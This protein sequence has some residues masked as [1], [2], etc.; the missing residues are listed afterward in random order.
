MILFSQ[1]LTFDFIDLSVD[2]SI[3]ANDDCRRVCVRE[4]VAGSSFGAKAGTSVRIVSPGRC[5]ALRMGTD[6]TFRPECSSS[7][8]AST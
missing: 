6:C 8:S 4:H 1:F 2:V 3:T 7:R 5:F